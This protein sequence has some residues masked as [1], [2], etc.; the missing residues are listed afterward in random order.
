MWTNCTK[1]LRKGLFQ[2]K[3]YLNV[4]SR[5]IMWLVS[6]KKCHDWEVSF[7]DMKILPLSCHVLW[8]RQV[9]QEVQGHVQ[10]NVARRD[11]ECM[12]RQLTGCSI[13]INHHPSST[14]TEYS[15]KGRNVPLLR[16]RRRKRMSSAQSVIEKSPRWSRCNTVKLPWRYLRNENKRRVWRVR[17]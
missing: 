13:K 1:C 9:N 2:L 4:R 16:Y 15:D 14:L 5:M 10:Q 7:C 3:L 17:R 6:E 12:E 11:W 8:N